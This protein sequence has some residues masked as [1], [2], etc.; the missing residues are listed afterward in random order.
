MFVIFPDDEARMEI[1]KQKSQSLQQRSRSPGRMEKQVKQIE[2]ER[3]YYKQEA[4][5]VQKMM[6][7]WKNKTPLVRKLDRTK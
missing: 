1:G 2:D 4:D 7:N 5:T 6:T 3:D